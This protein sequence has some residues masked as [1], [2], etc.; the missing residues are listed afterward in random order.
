VRSTGP[1]VAAERRYEASLQTYSWPVGV[2]ALVALQERYTH[3]L[4]GTATAL[5]AGWGRPR[6][7]EPG[8]LS[9]ADVETFGV[10]QTIR[11]LLGLPK[12]P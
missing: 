10:D 4:V 5:E 9:E 6:P 7:A 3:S 1:F 8:T 11:G 12:S 2:Q